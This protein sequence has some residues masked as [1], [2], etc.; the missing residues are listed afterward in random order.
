MSDTPKLTCV[1]RLDSIKLDETY[2]TEEGYLIDHPIVTSVGI[3]E[4]KNPDGTIRRELRLPEHVFDPKSLA[5]YEGKPVIITHVPR[6]NKHNVED[7]IVGTLLSKGYRDGDDVRAKIIIHGIDR[8]K[9][10]GL[11]EL[12]L[13]YDLD[14]D[15]TPGEWNGQPYD[16]IQTEIRINH[17]ALVGA[18][19][20]GDQ[21]RLNIDGETK[22]LRGGKTVKDKT[23]GKAMGSEQLQ[24]TIAAYQTRR[25]QRLD[26]AE[27]HSE[28]NENP[29]PAAAAGGE[30]PA[31]PPAEN[32]PSDKLQLIKDRRDRRDKEDNPATLDD[33][34][35]AIAQ[36][37]EDIGALI[38][39]IE[40]LQA[41]SDFDNASVP[42]AA[43]DDDDS[44]T[45]S[46]GEVEG[47]AMSTNAD[48]VDA[49]V[50]E[51]IKLGRIGDRLRLDGLEDMKPIDAKKAIIC[52]VNPGMRLDGKSSVYVN[53]AFDVA[54]SQMETVK[55]TNH[56]RRQISGRMDSSDYV[57]P[58]GKTA[59]QRARERMIEKQMN[60]GNE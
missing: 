49:V 58:N 7:E 28:D 9:R 53:A 11:R 12:S 15:E 23:K 14:L 52:K 2:F 40:E 25:Q 5:T 29:V 19:R 18:A 17:L 22:T 50:R 41:K 33:A 37:D 1:T 44:D 48:S 56:Q 35:G 59:A 38:E 51:R 34:M 47:S 6:V 24:K 43:A 36:Q 21:A 20:A 39:L 31:P 8:V 26:E 32:N 4:Y 10:S 54:V 30:I 45:N 57:A 55:D 13:G 27:K 60:G 46:M 3:F 16:A 42:A